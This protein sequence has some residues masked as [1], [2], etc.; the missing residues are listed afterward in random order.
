[1]KAFQT[2]NLRNIAVIGHGDA[3][4]TQLVS[5]LLHVAGATS[6]WGKVADGTTVTDFDEDSIARK[7]SLNNNF[8]HLEYKDTKINLIDTPGYAAFVAHARPALRVADCALV[9]VDGVNG[10]EVQTEK[11]WQY[12]NEFLL[13]RFMVIN[14]MDK[15]RA[16]FGHALDT[17]KESFARSIVPFTLPI[18]QEA[19]FRGVVD[20]VHQKAY[21]FDQGGKAKEVPIPEEGREVVDATR[22]RL[23]EIVA[24]SDDALME[25]YFENGTL[26]EEDIYPNLA[27]AIAGSK[28]CPVYAV[29]S[30]TLAGLSILL[31]HIVEFAPNPATH[32]AEFGFASAEKDGD[33]I[34]RKYSNDEPF[35]AYVFRTIA[36]PFA[37]R[38][39]VMKVVSGKISSDA[40]VYNSNRD[41]AERLGAL[42]VLQGKNLDKV[43]EAQTG[44]I[45]AVVKLKETQTGDTLC[46]KAKLIVYPPVEYPEAAI[47]FAIEPKSRADEDKISSALHKIL[48]EDPSLHF[49]RDAQT[50]EFILSGSGQLHIETVVDKLRNRYHV[51][52]AL[53]PPKVPY[54]E[55]I[56][57]QVEVQGRHK[58]QSGGR[59]QFGDCKCV[60]EPLERGAGFEWVDKIFGGAIPQNFRPAIEKGIIEAAQGGAIAGYPLVD[61]KVTLVDGSY[62][63]VDSDEHSFRAAGRKAFRNAIEKAKPTLLEPIMDVEVFCPIEVSGDI[64]GDLNSRRGRVSGMDMRGKQQV[65]KAQVPLSEMLD[66][67][68][69]LNSVTQARGSYHMQFSHYDPLPGNLSAKV[70]EQA[71]AEGRIRTH[72]EDE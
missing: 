36:D 62:H 7:I 3:G 35:S 30:E 11:T 67:Q 66:Y 50:K 37:G 65:I 52:V 56:T 28:L 47:S 2:E 19:N 17:A 38:I 59:G 6:R 5:S 69:K 13:P 60:F 12:A 40:T 64:M 45:I 26:D 20:V 33:R 42:H 70:I 27:K 23:I 58:K 61:F 49:D 1:M 41:T 53:H 21:E 63:T 29:S 46:D 44:D 54:K 57:A 43:N 48:E 51:E 32:E 31:D 4:K 24:E 39:N 18:G 9:V 71:R 16:D 14:K 8:A 68:S 25:K 22:E 55:T 72:D 10:I 34:T 15:E